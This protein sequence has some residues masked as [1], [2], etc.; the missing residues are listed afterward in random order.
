MSDETK[1][2]DLFEE[3]NI[4]NMPEGD[5]VIDAIAA[6]DHI[7]ALQGRIRDLERQL[8][9]KEYELD[10]SGA[11]A[12]LNVASHIAGGYAAAGHLPAL[13]GETRMTAAMRW[14]DEI[15]TAFEEKMENRAAEW[16]AAALQQKQAD[17]ANTPMR[18]N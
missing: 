18:E 6:A 9:Q 16:A 5:P 8:Q 7:K 11:L 3:G 13:A 10:I 17:D 15:V 14:A 12:R 1:T 4:V 2:D